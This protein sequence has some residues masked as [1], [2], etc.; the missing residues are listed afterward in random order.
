[1]SLSARSESPFV[2]LGSFEAPSEASVKRLGL[3]SP[4]VEAFMTEDAGGYDASG[5]GARRVLLAELHDEELDAAIYELVGETASFASVNRSAVVATG[6][7]ESPRSLARA[8]YAL[9]TCA[10]RSPRK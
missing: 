1:M 5:A 10:F 7:P 9:T 3:S 2:D 8:L 4:F 6:S